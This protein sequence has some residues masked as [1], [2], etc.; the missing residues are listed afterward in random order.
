MK[1]LPDLA[2]SRLNE[3][4]DWKIS[5]NIQDTCL[6]ITGLSTLGTFKIVRLMCPCMNVRG[7]LV[8]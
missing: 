1:D 2:L 6:F 4:Q 3:C 7:L 5:K 8:P